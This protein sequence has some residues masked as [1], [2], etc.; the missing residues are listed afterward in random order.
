MLEGKCQDH[1][2]YNVPVHIHCAAYPALDALLTQESAS[3]DEKKPYPTHSRLW[4]KK[5]QR[6]KNP[7]LLTTELGRSA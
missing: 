1:F 7:S 4:K 2:V 5:I 3:E 6:E